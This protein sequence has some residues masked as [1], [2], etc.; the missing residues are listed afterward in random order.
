MERDG[1][2]AW[3]VRGG[4]TIDGAVKARV[5]CQGQ[6]S[7]LSRSL[8]VCVHL[9]STHLRALRFCSLFRDS[10]EQLLLNFKVKVKEFVV[11]F[12]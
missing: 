6:Q 11:F 4:A 1:G 9:H 5:M 12:C 2:G 8:R 10:I 7:T 3:R